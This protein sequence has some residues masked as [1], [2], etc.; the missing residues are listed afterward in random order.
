MAATFV[1]MHTF[2]AHEARPRGRTAG[3]VAAA[4]AALALT[5]T[6][7]APPASAQAP[8][9]PILFIHGH[10]GNAGEWNTM[11]QRFVNAGYPA[12]HLTAMSY[13][14]QNTSNRITAH[15]V[16]REVDA[17]RAR[18]GAAK[19]DIVTHSMGGSNSRYYMKF[20]GGAAAV[21]DWVSLAGP[22]HGIEA[23][24][25]CAPFSVTCAE[26][27]PQ[28]D[29]P[30]L[31]ELNAGDETPG[32]V[33][34]GTFWSACDG[35]VPGASTILAGATNTQVGCVF[36]TLFPGDLDIFNRVRAFVA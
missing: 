35:G 26:M 10:G 32:A 33:N 19:V 16:A 23:A 4:V 7:A 20:L 36:H 12:S 17:L 31:Q 22:N 8:P 1:P 28:A 21:D 27:V 2:T 13:D 34:Y 15:D 5:L 24:R 3:L 14:S 9:D 30:F 11:I 18:T 29:S 25:L 6:A